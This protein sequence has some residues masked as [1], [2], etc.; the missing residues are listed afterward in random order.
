M[1]NKAAMKNCISGFEDKK[2]DILIIQFQ[3]ND[4]RH[5]NTEKSITSIHNIYF[6]KESYWKNARA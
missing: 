6:P 5:N 3:S 1:T 2:R 4:M